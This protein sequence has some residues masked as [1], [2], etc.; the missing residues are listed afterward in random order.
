MKKSYYITTPIYY[1]SGKLHLGHAY[2][3]IAGD[4]IKKHHEQKGEDV[5]YLTGSDEHGEK[6]EEKANEQGLAPQEY[7]DGIVEGIKEMWELLEIDYDK[8]IRTTDED[9]IR[10]V[11]VIFNRLLD[12]GDIY[13]GEYVGLYC[14]SCESYY[15]ETQAEENKCP[16]CGKELR[17]L[18]EECYF[19]KCSKYVDR[20]VDYLESNEDF[21][22]PIERKNELINNFIKP[23]LQ[24]LAVSRTNFKWGIP[25]DANPE[26]VIY[27]WIDALTNYIT[28]LGYVDDHENFKKYWPANV[29]LLGKEITRF[30]VIYWPMILMALDVELPEK[31]FAHGW[32]LMDRDKMSKSKGNIVYPEFL[33]ERYGVDTIR[34]YLMRE[35]P[36]GTDGMFTPESYINRI[37]N[38]LAND[39]GNLVNRTVAMCNKYFDGVIHQS[40]FNNEYTK[41]LIESREELNKIYYSTFDDMIFSQN[42]QA[43]WKNIGQTNKLIDLTEPWVLFKNNELDTLNEVMYTLLNQIEYLSVLLAPYMRNTSISIM[44]IIGADIQEF[45]YER[46]LPSEYKVQEEPKI[47]FARLDTEE[48]IKFIQNV[49]DEQKKAAQEKLA[50]DSK[51]KIEF[52]DFTKVEQVVVEVIE[53]NLH[54]NAKKLLV[55]K[56][57]AG[58]YGTK[59]IVSGIADFYKPEDLVGLK[60]ISVNNLE[61]RK[62]RGEISE[63]MI[64]TTGDDNNIKLVTI[65]KEHENGSVLL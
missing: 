18:K 23:G 19:F 38:D 26:H 17:E 64:L 47:L 37:N 46:G 11:K 62:L 30:H 7:V 41:A 36:F 58:K 2:T 43:I 1:P 50:V 55:L 60:L 31:L 15:T 29:Q 3:T 8:F 16:D 49:M 52:E 4:V 40:A 35:V 54:K 5:F 25:V 39:I 34:Y 13:L 48:E 21:L 44:D 33:V 42:L 61:P 12:N 28:A 45:Q 10:Q 65:G 22:K 51:E 14:T 27:V 57:D 53:A 20:L 56:V 6:I 9:H 24:D 59:Q 63:G 32:L